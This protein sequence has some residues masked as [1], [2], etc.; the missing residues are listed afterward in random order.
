MK[1]L[2]LTS[3]LLFS[4]LMFSTPSYAE[5]TEV[6]GDVKGNTFYV[7]FE[8]I[9]KHDGYV[10]FWMLTDYLKPTEYGDL[11]GKGYYQGDCKLFRHL[12]LSASFYKRPMGEGTGDDVKITPKHK[13]WEHPHPNS[14]I[15][16]ILKQVCSK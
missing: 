16:E 15:E 6:T 10:Y 13:D 2:L 14:S 11:S 8:R 4:T 5:W 1:K 12:W 7:D 3:T 9:R